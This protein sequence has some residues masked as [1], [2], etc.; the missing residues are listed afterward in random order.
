[1]NKWMPISCKTHFS[2]LKGFSKS[3]KLAKK[4]KEYGYSAC[5]ISDL[6]NVSGAVNFH[7]ACREHNIKPLLG[8]DFGSYILIAKNKEGWLDLIKIVSQEGLEMFKELS[9]K[10]NLLCITPKKENGYASLFGSNY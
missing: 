8:C 2:L 7:Q 3:E 4:C 10:G 6:Q 1:M 9:K 5:V